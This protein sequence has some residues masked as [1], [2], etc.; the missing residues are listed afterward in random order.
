MKAGEIALV[1]PHTFYWEGPSVALM[2]WWGCGYRV[3]RSSRSNSVPS[4]LAGRRVRFD[5]GQP[6]VQQLPGAT[7][8]ICWCEMLPLGTGFAAAQASLGV[9]RCLRSTTP[10][11]PAR[12]VL[13]PRLACVPTP[14]GA[15]M[16]S[17][18]LSGVA[19][20]RF[21]PS[22]AVAAGSCLDRGLQCH[23]GSIEDVSGDM[24]ARRRRAT[25]WCFWAA[26]R[27]G[28]CDEQALGHQVCSPCSLRETEDMYR[29]VV[30]PPSC[31]R[32]YPPSPSLPSSSCRLAPCSLD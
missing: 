10:T 30:Q 19:P 22:N 7:D 21:R 15:L 13:P 18:L 23:A 27:S 32:S 6:R 9:A 4:Q 24:R 14:L 2:R 3:G 26:W 20:V 12:R 31:P 1:G 5:P 29:P 25:L 11:A 8:T 17:Q 16:N 28:A